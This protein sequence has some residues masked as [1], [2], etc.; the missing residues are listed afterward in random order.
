MI[1]PC[2]SNCCPQLRRHQATSGSVEKVSMSLDSKVGTYRRILLISLLLLS[3][4]KLQWRICDHGHF[5]H[6]RKQ[7]CPITETDCLKRRKKGPV[8]G[9]Y[10]SKIDCQEFSINADLHPLYSFSINLYP[11]PSYHTITDFI[12]FAYT[13]YAMLLCPIASLLQ[14]SHLSGNDVLLLFTVSRDTYITH[15]RKLWGNPQCMRMCHAT[16]SEGRLS[17][18]LQGTL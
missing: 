11:L 9:I 15:S 5:L 14:I 2:Q 13:F 17:R 18:F 10:T 1:N 7:W 12:L 8:W 16:S 6:R 3:F 4:C